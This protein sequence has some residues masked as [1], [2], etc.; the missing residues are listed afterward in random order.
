MTVAELRDYLDRYD[1]TDEVRVNISI[2][3]DED[4]TKEEIYEDISWIEHKVFMES[5]DINNFV[6]L[7]VPVFLD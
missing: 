6:T 5:D 3:N 1:D 2:Y 4:G 7:N